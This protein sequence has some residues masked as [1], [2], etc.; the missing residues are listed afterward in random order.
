M[1]IR[2]NI[3][4][5]RCGAGGVHCYCCNPDRFNTGSSGR[6]ARARNRSLT[7]GTVRTLTRDFD[8][9][10]LARDPY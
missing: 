8:R 1:S 3:L 6:R 7:R 5:S 2:T 10:D 9:R 4:H